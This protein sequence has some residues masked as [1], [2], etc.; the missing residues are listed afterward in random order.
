MP[1]VENSG[2]NVL[3]WCASHR[4]ARGTT[5]DVCSRCHQHLANQPHAFDKWLQP[6]GEGEPQGTD[7]W[8]G[9][10]EHP[11]YAYVQTD[12]AVCGA[13][14]TSLDDR[15]SGDCCSTPEVA[16]ISHTARLRVTRPI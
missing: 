14:L 5:Y 8:A 6:S 1:R 15:R 2:E 9:D 7:G 12:C 13:R 10:V 4:Q 16:R 11:A 3:D